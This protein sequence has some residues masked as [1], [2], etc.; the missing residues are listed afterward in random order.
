MS[1]FREHKL[2]FAVIGIA[3]IACT[4]MCCFRWSVESKA[5]KVD[6]VYDYEEMTKLADQSDH[7]VTWWMEKFRDMGMKKVGLQEESLDSLEKDEQGVETKLVSDVQEDADW[8]DKY[9]QQ[10]LDVIDSRSKDDYDLIVKIDNKEMFDFVS[11]AFKARYDKDKSVSIP[12]DDGGYIY[13]DGDVS[14]SLY[15]DNVRL[16]DT[17]GD[18]FRSVQKMEG[19][20]ISYLNLG[21]LPE[22]VKQIQ[23]AGV[24]VI[25]RTM[26][27]KGWNGTRFVKDVTAQYE[28]LLGGTPEYMILASEEVPGYD[29]GTQYLS[30]YIKDNNVKIGIVETTNQRKNINPDGLTSVI[31]A[32]DYNAVRVFSVWDYIQYR[33]KYY[34]YDSYQEF[35][36][37]LFRAVVER[38]VRMVYFKPM[39]EKDNSFEYITD[40]KDY[41]DMF[42]DLNSRLE[43]HGFT[44]GDASIMKAV[45]VPL[46][47]KLL[48]GFADVAAAVI[49]LCS[50]FPIKSRKWKYGLFGL[51]VLCVLGAYFVAPNMALTI[52]SLAAAIF[53][54]CLTVIWFIHYALETKQR[55]GTDAAVRG[56]LPRSIAA[57]VITTVM[58][59]ATAVIMCAPLSDIT[60]LLELETYRGIKLAQI[61]VIAFFML[62]F[63]IF[64][65]YIWGKK[66]EP[67]LTGGDIKSLLRWKIEIWIVIIAG[68]MA[69][70]GFVYLSRT[71]N[72]SSVEPSNLE[73]MFRSFL[74]NHLYA[75]PRT[76][77]FLFAFPCVMMF[78]YSMV[79][80]SRL[81]SFIFGT[82]AA[83]GFTSVVNTFMHIRTPLELSFARTG[84]SLLFGLIIGIVCVIVL[85]LIYR[86][87]SRA[88]KKNR[89]GESSGAAD[90]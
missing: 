26:G 71:G 66:Q 69:A 32:T 6:F 88:V 89:A 40:V 33:Y 67:Y 77:E 74:E 48:A 53:V 2:L 28:K 5:K 49:I 9:P 21:M 34:G 12:T 30:D 18:G 56:I 36:N 11:R 87:V 73:L 58:S 4:I 78:V 50:I 46:I 68:V 29:D 61:A 8:R 62:M 47:V 59:L 31:K 14:D 52:T 37:T 43:A 19:S 17:E 35:E 20:K 1:F 90:A 22:K 51:G 55:L 72:D 15:G 82:G 44:I 38:N 79:R 16:T 45:S 84:F 42:S 63:F 86:T 23:D 80:G 65:G 7:D 70:V 83:I 57:L 24:E 27:Y 60:H 81:L 3:L 85:D 76:K 64:Y 75:R 13:I 41:Q 25:P 10:V 39:K 54:P